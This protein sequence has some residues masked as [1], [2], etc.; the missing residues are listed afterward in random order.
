MTFS[1]IQTFHI[2]L[3][4][5]SVHAHD[6]LSNWRTFQS[7]A[8]VAFNFVFYFTRAPWYPISNQYLRATAI[9]TVFWIFLQLTNVHHSPGLH[10]K[11]N[12]KLNQLKRLIYK[13][14]ARCTPWSENF[15]KSRKVNSDFSSVFNKLEEKREYCLIVSL[16]RGFNEPELVNAQLVFSHLESLENS[17]EDSR[18]VLFCPI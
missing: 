15:N 6:R 16:I 8:F 4:I 11:T 18:G 1:V 13:K 14:T 10:S 12:V 2:P 3:F 9:W 5:F 17:K 7:C